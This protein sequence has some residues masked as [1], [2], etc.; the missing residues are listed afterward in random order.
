MANQIQLEVFIGLFVAL[1]AVMQWF[2]KLPSIKTI[3]DLSA[4]LNSRGGNIL[5][6]GSMAVFFFMIAVRFTYYVMSL[7]ING[8]LDASDSI[9]MAAFTWITGSAFGGAFTSMVK[10]MTG[11]DPPNKNGPVTGRDAIG[12]IPNVTNSSPTGA[13]KTP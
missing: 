9:A 8:K 6:L 2:N 5:V 12:E 10:A 7:S 3:S 4:T 1:L 11:E 13:G